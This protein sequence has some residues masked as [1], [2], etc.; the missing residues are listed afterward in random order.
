MKSEQLVE[1]NMK[2]VYSFINKNYPTFKYDEDLIQCGMIGLCKAA[3]TWDESKSQFST[4]AVTCIRNEV[5]R[6]LGRRMRQPQTISLNYNYDNSDND[7][8]LNDFLV[9][10]DDIDFFD[11]ETISSKLSPQ[12]KRVFELL[13]D[14]RSAND[15]T[16]YGGWSRQYT[17]QCIRKIKNLWRKHYGS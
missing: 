1:E 12:E 11:S 5:R 2:L 4:Y 8:D 14:G 9:G 13:M 7:C 16:K 10:D 17:N 15:I 3:N 6:E